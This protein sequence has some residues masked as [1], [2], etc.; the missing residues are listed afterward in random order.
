MI[1]PTV[2]DY[3]IRDKLREEGMEVAH[4]ALEAG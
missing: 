2:A 1:G 4:R 3:Q